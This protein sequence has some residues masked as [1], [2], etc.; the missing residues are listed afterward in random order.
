[1]K[2]DF[3]IIGGGASGHLIANKL[4]GKYQVAIVEKGLDHNFLDNFLINF[5]IGSF[6]NLNIKKLTKNYICESSKYLKH[7][8]LKW[9]R[10][11]TLGGSSSINGLVYKR[12][13]EDDFNDLYKKE[14]I[15]IEWKQIKELYSENE[16]E[17]GIKINDNYQNS[18]RDHNDIVDKFLES[19]ENRSFKKLNSFLENSDFISSC[20]KYDL[21]LKNGK[22]TYSKNIYKI[23]KNH[24]KIFT[25]SLVSKILIENKKAI[26]V[27][28]IK[29]KKRIK[30]YCNK[31][32]VLSAGTINSPKILQL[33]GIG[34]ENFLKNF[35]IKINQNN[36]FVGKNLRDHLQTKLTYQINTRSNFNY[37]RKNTFGFFFFKNVLKYLISKQGMFAS[38]P[39]QAG[40]FPGKNHGYQKYNFQLNLLLGSGSSIKSVDKFSGITLS[41]NTLNPDSNGYVNIK[42]NNPRIDPTI[43]PNYF[44]K[45]TDL[46][47]HLNG[48]KLIRDIIKTR[49]LSDLIIKEIIPGENVSSKDE[50]IDF[51][52]DTSETIYHPSGTCKLGKVNEGVV[53][54]NFRVHGI[55]NLRVCDASILP[56]S[57]SG[58]LGA[59]CY[60]L[61]LI[62]SKKLDE[63]N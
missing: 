33:S 25:Q 56:N 17:L 9:P 2:F 37:L 49:P 30:I 55:E 16:K 18:L 5:P 62:L 58:N 43:Q 12:G 21:T 23:K 26:G 6:V 28:F 40:A 27:E 31:E 24:L 60:L 50:L 20:A 36:N 15:D 42:S 41:V 22:R 8:K 48:I 4:S 59:T 57:I 61:G 47:K 39:I 46:E 19:C 7:R 52:K 13:E 29:N 45:N 54:H 35:N 38:G 3:I 32:I 14:L 51:I 10:G 63:Y 44:E 53:D 1:M 11:E 34:D